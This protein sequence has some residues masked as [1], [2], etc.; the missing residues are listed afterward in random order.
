MIYGITV[1]VIYNQV[2][3]VYVM[4]EI[5]KEYLYVMEVC[6]NKLNITQTHQHTYVLK[7]W[8]CVTHCEVFYS[9]KDN[10]NE[11]LGQKFDPTNT[12]F[13]K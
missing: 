3:Y 10:N 6:H 8:H 1:V 4:L 9:I 2:N 5:L 13:D 12:V 11:V 7:L